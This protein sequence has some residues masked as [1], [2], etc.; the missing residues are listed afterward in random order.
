MAPLAL[1]HGNPETPA[2][3]DHLAPLLEAAGRDPVRLSPPGFGAAVAPDFQVTPAGYRDWLIG[4][5][6]RFDEPVDVVG[7]DLGGVF[8]I[9]AVIGRPDLIRSWASDSVGVLHPDYTWH[10]R[11]QM[12]QTPEAGEAWVKRT[13]NAPRTEWASLLVSIGMA[14][15]IADRV[16]PSFDAAMGRCILE[17]YRA[18]RQPVMAE[19]GRDLAAAARRPGLGIIARGDGNVGTLAQRHEACRTA[20]AEGVE[21]DAGHWWMTDGDQDAVLSALTDLWA[22]GG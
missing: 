19:R 5:L 18:A 6:E 20:G 8:V 9:L 2:V 4:E 17:L 15:P 13:L 14:A 1:V 12:W 16:A 22:R 10:E 11:A 3:W 21:V 7:H